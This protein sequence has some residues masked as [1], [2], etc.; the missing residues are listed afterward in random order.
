MA[1]ASNLLDGSN[2]PNCSKPM[3][4]GEIRIEHYLRNKKITY[5]KEKTFKGCKNDILLRFDFYLPENNTC[6]EYDGE[7]HFRPVEYF[8][9]MD[10]YKKIKENDNIKNKYCENNNI[11]LIRI[12]YT[13]EDIEGYIS[14]ALALTK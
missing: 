2:C 9:G 14:K 12:P 1:W 11:R 13:Q 3:S 8:G 10:K 7:Q 6:I 4:N 5:H